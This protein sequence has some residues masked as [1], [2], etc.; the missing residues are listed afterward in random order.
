MFQPKSICVLLCLIGL[1]AMPVYAANL[2]DVVTITGFIDNHIRYIDNISTAEEDNN[3]GPGEVPDNGNLTTDNDHEFSGRTRGR[4]FFNLSPNPFSKAVFGF[5]LDQTWGQDGTNDAGGSTGF[6]LGI[7]NNVFELKQLYVD[8]KV[9]STPLRFEVGGFGI[10][11]TR[12]KRCVVFCDDAG[13]IAMAGSWSSQI[14]TYTWYI[15]S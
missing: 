15:M 7:D 11:G 5:E 6:D 8:I 1:V 14:Q 12:L 10:N 9:P 13:G 4:I 2:D 3:R